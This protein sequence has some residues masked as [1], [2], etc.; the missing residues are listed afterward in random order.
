MN[1]SQILP[2]AGG[3]NPPAELFTDATAADY[4]GN[5]QSRA[6]RSWRAT[7]GLPF[8]KITNKVIRIRRAD[9]DRWL[10]Q[11]RVAMMKGGAQ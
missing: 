2:A 11:H 7:S 9:L 10:Q 4:I 5:V 8:L 3:Q 6:V 1:A